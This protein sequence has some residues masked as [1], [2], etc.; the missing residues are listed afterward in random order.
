[1]IIRG[2]IYIFKLI[3][4]FLDPSILTITSCY[5]QSEKNWEKFASKLF[6]ENFF[7]Q[8]I[9]IVGSTIEGEKNIVAILP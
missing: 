4:L 9:K 3:R 1:M 7:F 2:L 8:G 6:E 5:G